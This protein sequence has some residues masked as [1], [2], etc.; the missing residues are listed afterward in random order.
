[1]K[2]CLRIQPKEQRSGFTL[3]ELLVV[4]A[5]IAILASM[6]LPALSRAK[7]KALRIKCCSNLHQLGIALFMY[8]D[9]NRGMFPDCT[10]GYWPW[11]IPASAA[12]AI[13]NYGGKRHILYCPASQFQDN[14]ELWAFTTGVTNEVAPPNTS[15]YRVIG[16]A[17]AFKGA[18]RVLA[19]NITESINPRPWHIR[20]GVTINPPSTER[21]IVA[22]ATLSIGANMVDRTKNQYRDIQGGWRGGKHRTSH[23]NGN[24]PEGGNLLY[25]DGH[26]AWKNFD[27]MVVRT[28]GNPAFWW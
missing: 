22:D 19:T 25:L 18:A 16:Y 7:A 21:V 2:K 17:V 23:L 8:A 9:D 10:G 3:I 20:P 24:M 12:N 27:K 11:D 14:P 1:M 6:L 5:I 15:G 4:I 26:V 13:V 28:V